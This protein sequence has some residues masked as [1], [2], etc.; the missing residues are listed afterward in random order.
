MNE[1]LKKWFAYLIAISAGIVITLIDSN[2][3]WDDTGITAGMIFCSCAFLGFISPGR[4][5]IW[6]LVVAIW[7]PLYGFL[8]MHN[9]GSILALIIGFAGSYA[10]AFGKRF[11][12]KY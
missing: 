9:Y 7:I 11:F 1:K 10:G 12:T 2:P 5:W 4:P 6:A 8:W 3:S